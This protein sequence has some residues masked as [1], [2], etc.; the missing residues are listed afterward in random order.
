MITCRPVCALARSLK[1]SD[2]LRAPLL[3][4]ATFVLLGATSATAAPPQAVIDR[5]LPETML[6]L[7]IDEVIVNEDGQLVAIGSLGDEVFELPLELLLQEFDGEC[8]ILDL[9]L[10]PINLNL[11]G[12]QVDTS[13]ICLVIY[14]D[15]D[16]GLLGNLLC[17]VAGLLDGGLDLGDILAGI[18]LEDLLDGLT[19]DQVADLL[20]GIR[21]LLNAALGEVLAPTSVVGVS[22]SENGGPGP[23]QGG[24]GGR[25]N[26][27]G[28]QQAQGGCDILN[29]SLGPVE[30]DLLGLVVELDDCDGGPVTVDITAVP[31]PGNL[32][33]NLLCSVARLLDRG[34][35]GP[36]L[37]NALRRVADEILALL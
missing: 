28:Q 20:D 11:L 4:L 15:P 5:L 13:P 16:G 8:G 29:L 21:D 33:G 23:G 37:A 14:A 6:P 7:Q 31:G 2:R 34:A 17:A 3:G 12:L 35:A 19:E 22:S 27:P 18:G 36:A 10:G 1:E 9:A 30:L 32:L 25:Q 26:A 24:G